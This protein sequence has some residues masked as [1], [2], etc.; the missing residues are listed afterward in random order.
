VK[1]L[2][3][4]GATVL[5]AAFTLPPPP[6]PHHPERVG[7]ALETLVQAIGRGDRAILANGL[8]IYSQTLGEV[9]PDELERF[10]AEFE[11]HDAQ[12]NAE[13]LELRDWGVLHVDEINPVY[14]IS[15]RRGA[16]HGLHWSAWIVQFHSDNLGVLRRADELWPFATG[17]HYFAPRNC[18]GVTSGGQ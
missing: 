7:C 15:I 4:M 12:N 3:A 5:L 1:A 13:R 17:T 10:F 9:T 6:P 14:V 16:G 8:K 11:A 2:F 18:S